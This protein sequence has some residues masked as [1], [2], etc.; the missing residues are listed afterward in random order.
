LFLIALVR[1]DVVH[2]SGSNILAEPRAHHAPRILIQ[3]PVALLS[4]SVCVASLVSRGALG[5]RLPFFWLRL[6]R[7]AVPLVDGYLWTARNAADSGHQ[8]LCASVAS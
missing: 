8:L 1:L 6:V 3:E 2:H 5:F 7:L 4:P